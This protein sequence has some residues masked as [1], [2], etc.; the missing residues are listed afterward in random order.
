MRFAW[1][2]RDA[3]QLELLRIGLGL[4]ILVSF[5]PLT[6]HLE[7]LYGDDGWVSR[8]AFETLRLED[9]WYSAFAYCHGSAILMVV[10]ASFLTTA[11]A[12]TLGWA[13]RWV[14]WPLWL[15]FV[16][17]LNRNP[18]LVYGA[19]LL[20][21]NLLLVVCIAPIGRWPTGPRARVC[22]ILVRWQ[23]ALVFFFTA[24]QKL[25]G[26]L[27][28]SGDAVWVALNNTEF[29]HTAMTEGL[30]QHFWLVNIATHAALL[31]ELAYPF[32]IWGSRT[33]AWMLLAAIAFHLGTTAL[34]G[35]YLFAWVAIV[36]HLSFVPTRLVE[37]VWMRARAWRT[38]SMAGL[39]LAFRL[40]QLDRQ[41]SSANTEGVSHAAD[42]TPANSVH[43]PP[44]DRG[45]VQ[46]TAR[47]AGAFDID[48]RLA[49]AVGGDPG[50]EWQDAR[51]SIR[52][53]CPDLRRWSG[54]RERATETGQ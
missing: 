4:A 15:L 9:G 48:T 32:L 41:A 54:P 2:S 36:G 14:K 45:R 43:R 40:D 7:E 25:R 21:A 11:V 44:R 47:R 49:E 24:V 8:K 20:I 16:S 51:G 26:E 13:V 29:S 30:A 42:C 3:P 34:F 23:M 10:H 22:L 19:D 37:A 35:L 28:W 18:A 31:F 46:S 5:I 38:S 27:W 33:R 53:R 52:G 39:A 17:Y 6:P 50:R 1:L 12:F